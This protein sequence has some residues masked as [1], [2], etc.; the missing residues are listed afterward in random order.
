QPLHH[1]HVGAAAGRLAKR[2]HLLEQRLIIAGGEESLRLVAVE[3]G[4]RREVRPEAHERDRAVLAAPRERLREGD[5]QPLA[6]ERADQTEARGGEA[7]LAAGGGD[8]QGT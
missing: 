5:A 1:Q 2:H 4:W 7:D 6:V 3:R 8:E